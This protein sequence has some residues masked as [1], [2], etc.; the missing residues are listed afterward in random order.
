MTFLLVNFAVKNAMFNLN[1][2]NR[3]VMAQYPSDMRIG[4]NGMC[5]QVRAVG[6]DPTNGD[7]YIFV[8]MSRKIMKLLHWERGGF[9]MYYKRLEQ[10]RFHRRYGRKCF[11]A[12]GCP[13]PCILPRHWSR[14][15]RSR[16]NG[17]LITAAVPWRI[18]MRPIPKRKWTV[19]WKN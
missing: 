5:G 11:R 16:R 7:V 12:R 13:A 6:L 1:E 2:N 14:N 4:V 8:G 15:R 17:V 18:P 19:F 10:G 3:F 9:A